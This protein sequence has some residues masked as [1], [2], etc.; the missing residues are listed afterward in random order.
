MIILNA[1]DLGRSTAETDAALAC[2]EAGRLSSATAMVFMVDS[3]RAAG[4]ANV[5]GLHVGLHLNL[6]EAFT[7]PGVPARLREAH[8][9]VVSFLT[10]GKFALLVYNPLLRRQFRL[11]VEAQL[12]E[13]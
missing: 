8:D 4:L 11:V 13:F 2:H 5:A 1:D 7:A 12:A 10:T 9:Q 3:H 6:S